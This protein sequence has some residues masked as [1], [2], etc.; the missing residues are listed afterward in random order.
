M[1]PVG[2]TCTALAAYLALVAAAFA[3]PATETGPSESPDPNWRGEPPKLGPT[4]D[5][6]LPTFEEA[7]L[8]SGLK[9][10]V[11][12]VERLPVVS[13]WLV[14]RGGAALDPQAQP[15]LSALTYGMLQEGAGDRDALA[16]SDAL[17][18]LGASFSARSERDRG[19][20]A[21]SGLARHKE[22][23]VA[24]LADAVRRPRLAAADFRRLK[25]KTLAGIQRQLGSP[26]GLAFLRLPE[27]V[28]GPEHPLG[29]PPT[30]TPESV[31]AA[32]VEDI[33]QHHGRLIAPDRSALIAVGDVGLDEMVALAERHFGD[34]NAEEATPIE[35]PPVEAD[36]ADG[37]IIFLDK[38]G[39]P[40]TMVILARPVFGRGHPEEDALTLANAAWGGSFSSRLNMNLREEKG[41]TYGAGSQVSFR[42]GVGVFVAYA[43]LQR[44][45]SAPGLQE[46][47]SELE[48]LTGEPL[49]EDELS[50]VKQGI[51]R[52]L[53]SDFEQIASLAGA[54]AQIFAYELPLDHYAQLAAR[55]ESA[56]LPEV[57]RA[58]QAYLTAE[59]MKVLMVGDAK[60]VV[61][62][63]ESVGFDKIQ[64][65]KP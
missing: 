63:L 61:P 19:S 35:I 21:I 29:H 62:A 57:N 50:R 54:A 27:L 60:T 48:R 26:Q 37:P 65:E 41:Y 8:P 11:A 17:A 32:T 43:A 16:F 59:R 5:L 3:N 42:N 7:A 52:G 34:W 13:I 6:V 25:A 55:L 22:A 1:R 10:L 56:G 49:G 38:P 30:G 4:P 53:P 9:V 18:D 58:A 47:Y 20:V 15:G 39:S 23:L 12:R 45:F 2:T 28:Y 44:A 40:Q 51:V 36:P 46:F 31:G 14:T 64:V 24:Q 33:R